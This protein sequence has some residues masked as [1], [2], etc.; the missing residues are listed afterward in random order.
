MPPGPSPA[1]ARERLYGTDRRDQLMACAR[2]LLRTRGL[3]ELTIEGIA[4]E[5]G[6]SRA[7]AYR[8][9][10]SI[11]EV[12]H[13]L[14]AL[15][16]LRFYEAVAAE[17]ERADRFEDEVRAGVAANFEYVATQGDLLRLIRPVL[18]ARR[19][20]QE[21]RVRVSAW[22][23]Y[24]CLRLEAA[25]EGSRPVTATL[26]RACIATETIC[27]NSWY[28]GGTERADATRLCIDMV[29]A[30]ISAGH[31]TRRPEA[32]GGAR[33]APPAFAAVLAGNT[34][35]DRELSHGRGGASRPADDGTWSTSA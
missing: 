35:D 28:L 12:L 17:I 15:E 10:K 32:A 34:P 4:V 14:Y 19:Y 25:Y 7:L 6:V 8:H 24:R 23:H 21:R 1:Q 13:E 11:D 33:P 30:A 3:D 20:R 18:G 26:V 5:A 29:F 2:Q 9:L 22:G 31:L 27:V 16:S